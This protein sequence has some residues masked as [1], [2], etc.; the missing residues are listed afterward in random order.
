M[1]KYDNN[2]SN[3]SDIKKAEIANGIASFFMISA[4]ISLKKKGGSIKKCTTTGCD[5]NYEEKN[6]G[7]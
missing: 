6:K 1:K 2:V 3:Y 5:K 7:K 4:E